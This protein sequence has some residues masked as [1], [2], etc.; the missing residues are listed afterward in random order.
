M[1]NIFL[2]PIMTEKWHGLH[3]VG[4]TRFQDT[5]DV[6]QVLFDSK[7]GALATGLDNDTEARLS[8]SL[9]VS[10][11]NNSANEFWH[12]FKIKLKDQ[13]MIFNTDNPIEELQVYVMKASKFIANSQKELDA[14]KWPSA[15]YVIYDEQTE[16]EKQASEVQTKAKAID[17]FNNLSP[18]KKL[19]MLKLYGKA[20]ENSSNDF[21]YTKL[22]EIVENDPIDFIAQANK[23]PEEIKIKALI[24][25][26]EKIGILRRKGTAYLYNDQQ[27]GFDYDDTVSYL[28]NPGNQ[29]L[30]VKLKDSLEMRQPSYSPKVEAKEE[31]IEEVKETKAT[32]KK[33]TKKD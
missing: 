8:S 14:G 20:T 24:F 2:K 18:E 4:R 22:Y 28:L 32:T 25:D 10:L 30:L 3:K 6:I 19:D 26:L 27:V 33:K 21:V 16:L 29:E 1:A 12:D 15:K 7:S 13:T 5:Q 31:I 9:G 11:A 17:I 23:S